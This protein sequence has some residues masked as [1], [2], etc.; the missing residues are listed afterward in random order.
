MQIKLI[1]IK[2]LGFFLIT[3][4]LLF[5]KNN[6]FRFI[7]LVFVICV[8]I[9]LKK[10][11]KYK[12]WLKILMIS[13][14]IIIFFNSVSFSNLSI[15][16]QGI[17]I[18]FGAGIKFLSLSSLAFVL[19]YSTDLNDFVKAIYFLPKNYIFVLTVAFALIPQLEKTYAKI[20]IAQKS[21]SHKFSLNIFKSYIPL[22]VPLFVRTL[23]RA[24]KLAISIE[25]R[26]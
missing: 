6:V 4:L 19:L 12:S 24:E 22:L 7:V 1:Q 15:D 11:K 23:K 18:G 3:N 10:L 8:I 26:S 21:R 14:F 20:K 13:I 17:I 9:Y 16:K 5:Y 25:T 2:I